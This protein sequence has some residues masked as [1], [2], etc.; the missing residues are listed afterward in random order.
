MHACRKDA[1]RHNEILH[2]YYVESG[3]S[4]FSPV[5]RNL[6]ALVPENQDPTT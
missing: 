1:G 6:T 5:Q 2:A 4:H 3:Y